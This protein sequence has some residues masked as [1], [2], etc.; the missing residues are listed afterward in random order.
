MDV[1]WLEQTEAD[2]PA[3]DDWF[4]TLEAARLNG[5]CFP[6]RRADWRLGRWTAKRALALY[7]NIPAHPESLAEIEVRPAASGAPEAFFA[8]KPA[9]ATVSLSHRSGRAVCAVARSGAALGC[10]LEMIEPRSEGFLTDYFTAQEQALVARAPAPG[11]PWLCTLL[12]SGKESAL[13]AL[14][15]GLRLDTRCVM[16]NP[17][18]ALVRP[19]EGGEGWAQ[20]PTFTIQASCWSSRWRPLQACYTDGQFF[21]GWWHNAGNLLRTMVSSPP[22]AP[23]IPLRIPT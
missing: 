12:W 11:Q 23:P 8:N 21:H 10:D 4:S 5:M 19:A 13:K 3:G 18:D 22:S 15:V 2:V 16:V 14:R 20:D 1:Y 6:K 7:L 17:V 9:P